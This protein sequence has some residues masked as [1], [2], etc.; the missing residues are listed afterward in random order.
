MSWRSSLASAA[1]KQ[2]IEIRT[3]RAKQLEVVP[4]EQP[5]ENQPPPD[6]RRGMRLVDF[7]ATLDPRFMPPEHLGGIG[8]IFERAARGEPVR[9]CISVPPRHGKT[10]LEIAAMVKRLY[11]QPS[12]QIGFASHGQRFAGN[13]SRRARDLAA[14]AGVQIAR[15]S[16]AR[17]DW[18]TGVDD[19]GVWATSIGGQ[20]TGNGFNLLVVDD[21]FEGRKEAESQLERDFVYD[22][23][24]SDAL[25]R[26]EPNGA[27]IVVHTRWHEDDLIGRLVQDGWEWLNLPALANDNDP[28]GR[29]PGEPLW[30]KRFTKEALLKIMN[31]PGMGGPDGYNWLS[32]YQ[33][34]PRPSSSRTFSGVF[35]A[36]TQPAPSQMRI[37]IGLDFAYSPKTRADASAA[38]VLGCYNGLY[39][40]LDV[41]TAREEPTSFRARCEVLQ[42]QY[43]EAVFAAYVPRTEEGT[44]SFFRE[45]IPSI[46]SLLANA[47]KGVRAIPTSDAWRTGKILV[48]R[49]APWVEPFLQELSAFTGVEDRHDDRVDALVAA[50]DRLASGGGRIDWAEHDRLWGGMPKAFE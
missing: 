25:T 10:E 9:A 12:T 45:R 1:T 41:V 46:L 38:V 36:A 31:T 32:L 5:E 24:Q 42:A 30:P 49:D 48:R 19:G 17:A 4:S 33:G 26:L 2:L 20:I 18:R 3:E 14:R 44:V 7:A 11:D 16:R 23:L 8:S 28:N 40:V 29:A 6:P 39:Y 21:P 47:P 37:C 35:Y 27:C 43:P 34:N 22:W 15:D 50:Y 13:K